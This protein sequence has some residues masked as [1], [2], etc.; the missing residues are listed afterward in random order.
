MSD[1]TERPAAIR[2]FLAVPVPPAVAGRLKDLQIRLRSVLPGT[3][4]SRPEQQH[5][6]IRFYGNVPVEELQHL[7]SA[8]Q[9]ACEQAPP[10]RLCA[11]K[12][13]TFADRIIWV[14][15]S[16]EVEE[17]R[18]LENRI[19]TTTRGIGDCREVRD[20]HPHLTIGRIKRRPPGQESIADRIR[21]WSNS[22]F[23]EWTVDHLELIQSDLS[24]QGARYT[25]LASIPLAGKAVGD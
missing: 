10:L 15:I 2:T 16:G 1:A 13:G 23:G 8:I 25:C 20:F 14:G 3:W 4:W 24:P 19:A 17:L 12:V 18:E 22:R 6:T 21:N 5:L 7:Q 11:D 9:Q